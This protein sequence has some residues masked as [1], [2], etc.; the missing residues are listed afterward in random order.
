MKN[1]VVYSSKTGNT[2]KLAEAIYDYL[3]GEKEIYPVEQAPDPN[4]YTFVAVGF[5]IENG[6][7]DK[8]TQ[9][10]LKK[11]IDEKELFLFVTHASKPGSEEVKKAINE[12]KELAKRAKIVG[13]FECLGEVPEEILA[14]ARKQ[15]PVP[16]WVKDAEAAKGHPN[17]EDI[18]RLIKLLNS[19]DLPL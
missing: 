14:E 7:P 8:A 13:V 11:F 1:L 2:K 16:E 10:Y 5:W 9:E 12:A 18:E 6:K 15:D 19:L 17:E 4:D 3:P